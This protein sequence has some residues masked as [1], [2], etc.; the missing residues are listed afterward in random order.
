MVER[1]AEFLSSTG[2]VDSTTQKAF[3]KGISGC[4]EHTQIM[5]ELLA[6]AR[7]KKRTVH[8]TY[9]DLADAFGS[10][11]HSLIYHPMEMSHIPSTV[12]RYKKLYSN[13]GYVY[14]PAWNSQPFKFRRGVFQGDPWSP[15]LFLLAFNPIIQDLKA[16][17]NRFGYYFNGQHVITLPYADDFC[18][19]T[20]NQR[21]H[22][23]LINSILEKTQ[24]MNLTLK[25]S[26]CRSISISQGQ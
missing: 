10:V 24:S 11:E 12:I 1:T 13:L 2:T 21:T 14:G 19:I 8:I 5:H 7:N 15:I 4:I 3:L 22:Q 18:L 20:L 25:P 26:K 6:N 9:F 16:Q 17:E 23:R